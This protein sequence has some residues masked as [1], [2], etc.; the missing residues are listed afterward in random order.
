MPAGI[1]GIQTAGCDVLPVPGVAIPGF[2]IPAFHA[3]MTS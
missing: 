2:W 1:A 3:G